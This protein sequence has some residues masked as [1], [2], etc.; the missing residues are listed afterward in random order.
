MLMLPCSAILSAVIPDGATD[1]GFT[2]DRHLK[3][4]KS[5]VADLDAP[6]RDPSCPERAEKWVPALARIPARCTSMLVTRSAR[7]TIE[8]FLHADIAPPS[9]CLAAPVAP[10]P[11][12]HP[13]CRT[14]GSRAPR[15]RS[16]AC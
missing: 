12:E 15:R 16:G 8:R 5:A 3:M 6:I 11:G 2:R 1:L 7:T 10:Y 13:R 9:V 14:R 4:S